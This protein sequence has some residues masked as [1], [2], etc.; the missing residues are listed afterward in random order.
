MLEVIPPLS[1]TPSWSGAHLKHTDNF[2]FTFTFKHCVRTLLG[3]ASVTHSNIP[4]REAAQIFCTGPNF[5]RRP[6]R[7]TLMSMCGPSCQEVK[8]PLAKCT[9]L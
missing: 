2:T 5:L 9:T 6:H 3:R 4:V 7:I 1:N 8:E